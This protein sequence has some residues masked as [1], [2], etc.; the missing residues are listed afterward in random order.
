MKHWFQELKHLL[1]KKALH[2]L[3]QLTIH[4]QDLLR[5]QIQLQFQL[6]TYPSF[7]HLLID[8]V[9]AI[10]NDLVKEE[11]RRLIADEKIRPDGRKPDEIRPHLMLLM[12]IQIKLEFVHV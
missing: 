9:Y 11:V 8:E 10:L 4:F 3:H 1:K 2:K 5:Q 6:L 7:R 12:L